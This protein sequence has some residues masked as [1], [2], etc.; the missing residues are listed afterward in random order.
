MSLATGM[1]VQTTIIE[2][3]NVQRG[4]ASSKPVQRIKSDAKRTPIL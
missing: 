2:K 4:S 1:L 3:I